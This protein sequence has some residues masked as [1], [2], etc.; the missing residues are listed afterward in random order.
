MLAELVDTIRKDAAFS[1]RLWAHVNSRP[2]LIEG[3]NTR[4]IHNATSALEC[5]ANPPDVSV[6]CFSVVTHD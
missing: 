4:V 3:Y 6:V 5:S 1:S 2:D